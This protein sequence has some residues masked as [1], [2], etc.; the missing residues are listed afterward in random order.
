MVKPVVVQLQLGHLAQLVESHTLDIV[1]QVMAQVPGGRNQ[2]KLAN[3]HRSTVSTTVN[4]PNVIET[5]TFPGSFSLSTFQIICRD[6]GKQ[7]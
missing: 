6:L 7:M 3:I 4:I 5:V 1:N 2:A